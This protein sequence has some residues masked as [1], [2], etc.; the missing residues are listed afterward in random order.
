MVDAFP[1]ISVSGA[2]SPSGL[3]TAPSNG[4]WQNNFTESD[5][6]DWIKGKHAI[7]MGGEFDKWQVNQDPFDFV[8]AGN[9]SFNGIFT[10]GPNP[11]NPTSAGL[12]YADLLLGLPNSWNILS[13]PITGGRVVNVQ[14][15]IQ[16]SFKLRPNLT[17]NY[18]VRYLYQSG[19]DGRT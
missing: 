16:D 12:G 3:G 5:T 4:L 1:N 18:G 9:F 11:Q 8:D 2:V 10:S 7:K 17:L 13:G 14:L 6:L 15:F 19:M